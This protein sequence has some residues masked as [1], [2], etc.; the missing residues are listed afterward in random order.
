MPTESVVT[1]RLGAFTSLE[2][3][4][5]G[6]TLILV[7]IELDVWLTIKNKK[8]EII[9]LLNRLTSKRN[10]K[11]SCVIL[12]EDVW[13]QKNEIVQSRLN[14]ILGIS[15]RI[16][17]R[18]TQVRKLDK[19]TANDFLDK[20]HLQGSATS[21]I[22]YGL[23]LPKRYFRVLNPDYQ[24]DTGI[25]ELLVAVATFSHP[26][27]F[28][29]QGKPFRS[30]ELIRFANLRNTTVV[31]G[32][33]KLIRAFTDHYEPGDI[34]TYAD[35]EWSDGASYRRLGFEEI[36]DKDPVSFWIDPFIN[37]RYSENRKPEI[38]GLIEI[39]NAGSRKFV[40]TFQ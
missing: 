36:S 16:P 35:L 6:N 5:S 20:N 2:I 27:T 1:E 9:G 29:K 28:E 39:Y 31:G 38:D 19:P 26:R 22:R 14:A 3:K 15:E 7:L 32:F 8:E 23:F 18:V 34:M 30:Y 11:I 40:K 33:D 37:M 4:H 24:I 21:R 10:Q 25:E 17:G 12:W 13:Y